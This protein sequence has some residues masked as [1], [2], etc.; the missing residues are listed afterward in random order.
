MS[1]VRKAIQATRTGEW[2]LARLPGYPRV[3]TGGVVGYV[4]N[5]VEVA[6]LRTTEVSLAGTVATESDKALI[7]A[8]KRI[9]C[10]SRFGIFQ[11]QGVGY[12]VQTRLV[13]FDRV[14]RLYPTREVE[15]LRSRLVEGEEE[16]LVMSD[17]LI[18]G[19]V[20]APVGPPELWGV[21]E[22]QT[23]HDCLKSMERFGWSYQDCVEDYSEDDE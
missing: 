5:R 20:I 8:G 6:V 18:A 21:A 22:V 14:E 15:L 9:S 3:V 23:I 17:A 12:R 10:G 4:G 2:V 1:A 16:A 7:Y 19:G 11:A 13:P